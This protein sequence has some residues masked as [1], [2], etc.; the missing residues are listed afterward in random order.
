MRRRTVLAT[1]AAAVT[2]GIAG[3]SGDG[4]STDAEAQ[5]P[6]PT[7]D[8][9]AEW[10]DGDRIDVASLE[11]VHVETAVEEGSFTVRST[12]DTSH[13]GDERPEEWLFSQDLV[14]RFDGEAELQTLSQ[15]LHDVDETTAAYVTTDRAYIR[16]Q[17]DE[18][19]EYQAQDLDRT[20]DTFRKI[21]RDEARTGLR[22]LGDWDLT[23]AESTTVDGR[24]AFHYEGSDYTGERSIPGDVEEADVDVLVDERG[25]VNRIEQTYLGEHEGQDAEIQVTIAYENLGETE[26]TEPDWVDEAREATDG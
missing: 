1:A 18:E 8:P 13:S 19:T 20:T 16:Y 4:S 5:T 11:E 23:Y 14:S 15:E 7:P 22:G 25:F 17:V 24:T 2:T 10:I 12:A 21:M 6:E 3:C 26:I 9:D